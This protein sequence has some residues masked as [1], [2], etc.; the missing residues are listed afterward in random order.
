MYRSYSIDEGLSLQPGPRQLN[1]R[2][3][4]PLHFPS[5][6]REPLAAQWEFEFCRNQN[7][8]IVPPGVKRGAMPTKYHPWNIIRA[9]VPAL[10]N[11]AA[12]SL[13]KI[14]HLLG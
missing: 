5:R 4:T 10:G 2:G 11:V 9:E 14:N 3:F 8:S 12:I 7:T 6:D 13:V 1:A